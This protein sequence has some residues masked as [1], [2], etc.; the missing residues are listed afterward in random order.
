MRSWRSFCEALHLTALGLWLGVLVAV[1][2]AAAVIFP[3]MKS[4]HIRLEDFKGDPADHWLIAA[5]QVAQRLFLLGDI[6]MFICSLL[7]V[8][9]LGTLAVFLGGMA[10]RGVMLIRALAVGVALASFASTLLIVAPGISTASRAHWEAARI[11]DDAASAKH[12]A[13]A[14]EL[15]PLASNLMAVEAVALLIALWAAGW[16]LASGAAIGAG[17]PRHPGKAD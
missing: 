5:G 6:A 16:S 3:T 17:G 10:R 8:L 4:M 13:A 1:G 15:H 2:G 12:S 9:T 14:R 11:G 7:T